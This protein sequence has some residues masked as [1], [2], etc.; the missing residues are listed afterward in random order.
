MRNRPTD[1]P[2]RFAFSGLLVLF[3]TVLPAAQ[4]DDKTYVIRNV[5]YS[6]VTLSPNTRR[7]SS[8]RGGSP[9]LVAP[10]SPYHLELRR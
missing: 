9:P 5:Q 10:A 8:V 2:I 1:M 3:A 6:T 7:L 4:S